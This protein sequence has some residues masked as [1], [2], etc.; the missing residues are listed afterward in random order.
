MRNPLVKVS[1]AVLMSAAV[2]LHADLAAQATS[3]GGSEIN[4]TNFKYAT[5]L[6]ESWRQA[7]RAATGLSNLNLFTFDQAASSYSV[8]SGGVTSTMT[9]TPGA[10]GFAW[11]TGGKLNTGS[12]RKFDFNFNGSTI[13][14]FSFRMYD[15]DAGTVLRIYD[16]TSSNSGELLWSWGSNST[17]TAGTQ[18][19]V[20]GAVPVSAGST[21]VTLPSAS[22]PLSGALFVGMKVAGSATYVTAGTTIT[23]INGGIIGLSNP[24]KASTSSL[25]LTFSPPGGTFGKFSKQVTYPRADLLGSA[26]KVGSWVTGTG[27][28]PLSFITA[29]NGN[30]LS[31]NNPTTA[32]GAGV[33]LTITRG[34]YAGSLNLTTT[35]G[36]AVAT[37]NGGLEALLG[38][39]GVANIYSTSRVSNNTA[40]PSI[41]VDRTSRFIQIPAAS[42]PLVAD[43]FVGMNV[44]GGLP[45]GTK[46]VSIVDAD[47]VELSNAPTSTAAT[48]TMTFAADAVNDAVVN[49]IDTANSRIT[50]SKAATYSA[51]FDAIAW[52]NAYLDSREGFYG[53][54]GLESGV[55]KIRLE[56]LGTGSSN[57][58]NVA[59]Y[60]STDTILHWNAANPQGLA[61]SGGDGSW[62]F[63]TTNW[64]SKPSSGSP[65]AF[66]DGKAV[67]FGGNQAGTVSLGGLGFS[68]GSMIFTQVTDP[69]A[70]PSRL[71]YVIGASAN[72]GTINLTEGSSIQTQRQATIRARIS[73]AYEKTGAAELIIEGTNNSGGL[74]KISQGRLQIMGTFGEQNSDILNSSQ[75]LINKTN[76]WTYANLLSGIGT[77]NKEGAGVLV[78]S[79]NNT[80]SGLTTIVAGPIV[81]GLPTGGLDIGAG[82]TEGALPGDINNGA[83]LRF[84]RSNDLT[85][86]KVISGSGAVTKL[87]AGTLTFLGANTYEGLTTISAG[88]LQIGNGASTGLG[89]AAAVVSDIKLDGATTELIYNNAGTKV[90]PGIISGTGKLTKRGS[91]TLQ[92][93][94]NNSYD[95]VTTI[96]SGRIDLASGSGLGSAVGHTIVQAGASLLLRDGF[97][98]AENITLIGTGDAS[99]GALRNISDT[100][101]LT[102]T[103]TLSGDTTLASGGGILDIHN[104]SGAGAKL[105][106]LST[107]ASNSAATAPLQLTNTVNLGSGRLEKTGEGSATLS[108][109]ANFTGGL[110]VLN[111]TL[112]AQSLTSFGQGTLVE[113][114]ATGVVNSPKLVI[115]NN[116]SF[117][118][119]VR[120]HEGEIAGPGTLTANTYDLRKGTVS[121]SLLGAVGLTKSSPDEV[122]LSGTNGYQGLTSVTGGVLAISNSQALGDLAAGTDV[123]AGGSL[124]LRK[125][126]GSYGLTINE[127]ITI[128]GAGNLGA[129]RNDIGVNTITSQLKLSGDA[130]I[131]ADGGGSKR[132]LQLAAVG[133]GS[134]HALTV[135]AESGAYVFFA[136]GYDLGGGRLVKK[137]AGILELSSAG[138]IDGSAQGD[139]VAIEIL[140]GRVVA[141]HAQAL[142]NGVVKVGSATLAGTL[143]IAVS[144]NLPGVLRLD[145]GLVSGVDLIAQS[146]D[147]RSGA[148]SA[149]L[150]TPSFPNPIALSKTSTGTVLLSG[151]NTYEGITEITGGV[152]QVGS[153]GL[154]SSADPL[155]D[156]TVVGRSGALE[157]TVGTTIANERIYIS[158]D[159]QGGFGALR[160]KGDGRSVAVTPTVIIDDLLDGVVTHGRINNR[161]WGDT[162]TLGGIQGANKDLYLGQWNSLAESDGRIHVNGPLSL[163]SGALIVEGREQSYYYVSDV[164]TVRL[165]GVGSF[166]GGTD[167]RSGVVIAAHP[168]AMGSGAITV[169]SATRRGVFRTAAALVGLGNITLVNGA[170]EGETIRGP[171]NVRFKYDIESPYV[172]LQKGRVSIGLAGA[173]SVAKTTAS[174]IGLNLANS[175]AGTTDVYAGILEMRNALSLG[176]AAAGTTVHPGATLKIARGRTVVANESLVLSGEGL[177]NIG[178]LHSAGGNNQWNGDISLDADARINASSTFTIGGASNLLGN[179]HDLKFGGSGAITLQK[180]LQLGLGSLIKDGYGSLT[181]A[182]AANVASTDLIRGR[183][184]LVGADLT[185]PTLTVR[186]GSVLAGYGR[187]FGDVTVVSGTN[188][189]LEPGT[190]TASAPAS[191]LS[192][193]TNS[194]TFADRATVRIQGLG[195]YRV[196]GSLDGPAPLVVNGDLTFGGAARRVKIAVSGGDPGPGKFRLF[197]YTGN[198][199]GDLSLGTLNPSILMSGVKKGFR[200]MFAFDQEVDGT[201]GRKFVTFTVQGSQLLWRG[202]RTNRWDIVTDNW[203]L[204]E[205]IT[206][207]VNV[208]QDDSTLFDD[209]ADGNTLIRVVPG[210]NGIKPVSS[211]TFANTDHR[212][213]LNPGKEYTLYRDTTLPDDNGTAVDLLQTESVTIG[214]PDV[215]PGKQ[216]GV[217]NIKTALKILPTPDLEVGET[218]YNG[219]ILNGGTLRIGH[220]QALGGA[221]VDLRGGRLTAFES[222]ARSVAGAHEVHLDSD[223]VVFGEAGHEG[224]LTFSSTFDFTDVAPRIFNVDA[225]AE[226]RLAGTVIGA[227]ITKRGTGTLTLSSADIFEGSVRV[228]NGILQLGAGGLNGSLDVDTDIDLAGGEFRFNRGGNPRGDSNSLAFA[229][230]IVGAGTL[231]KI[232]VGRVDLSGNHQIG[233]GAYI[234]QGNLAINGELTGSVTVTSGGILSGAGIVNGNV[235]VGNGARHEP[236]NSPGLATYNGNLTYT[237]GATIV[238]QLN[239]NTM[240][241][242]QAG[243]AYDRIVVNG[244]LAFGATPNT[245]QMAFKDT[246]VAGVPGEVDWTNDFWKTAQ[247]WKIFEVSGTT[248]GLSTGLLLGGVAGTYEDASSTQLSNVMAEAYFKITQVGQDVFLNY[249]PYSAQVTSPVDLGVAYVGS[250]F[251]QGNV[252]IRNSG[253]NPVDVELRDLVVRGVAPNKGPFGVIVPPGSNSVLGVQGGTADSSMLVEMN[254]THVGVVS[255]TIA[256]DFRENNGP[257]ST[258]EILTVRGTAYEQAAPRTDVVDFGAVRISDPNKG[259]H[260]AAGIAHLRTNFTQQRVQLYNDAHATYGEAMNASLSAPGAGLTVSSQVVQQVLPGTVN[261]DLWADLATPSVAGQ[262]NPQATLSGVSLKAHPDLPGANEKPLTAQQVQFT[263]KAYYHAFGVVTNAPGNLTY[264]FGSVRKGAAFSVSS[265]EVLNDVTPGAY[266]ENLGATLLANDGKIIT[267]GAITGLA[268]GEVNVA[269]PLTITLSSTRAGQIAGTATLILKTEPLAGSGLSSQEITRVEFAVT[270]EVI[271]PAQIDDSLFNLGRVHENGSFAVQQLPIKNLTEAPGYTDNLDVD[272][273]TWDPGLEVNGPMAIRGL[274][275][276]QVDSSISVKIADQY[277]GSRGVYTKY[278][279]LEGTSKSTDGTLTTP[280]GQTAIA[281]EGVVYNGKSTWLGGSDAWTNESWNRW[282]RTEGVPG[283]DG[284]LSTYDSATFA[285][286]ENQNRTVIL[287]GYNPELARLAFGGTSGT[288]LRSAVAEEI[289]LGG[290]GLPTAAEVYIGASAHRIDTKLNLKQ[291]LLIKVDGLRG[292]FAGTIQATDAQSKDIWLQG[293]G[294]V[295]FISAVTGNGWDMNVT[296]QGPTLITQSQDFDQFKLEAGAVIS[297]HY[298]DGDPT[299]RVVNAA[300]CLKLTGDTVS[301]GTATQADRSAAELLKI[302]SLAPVDVQAG[303]LYNNAVIDA[304]VVVR[305]G[306]KLGGVGY[307]GPIQ[308]AQGGT[309]A[310]GN[311]IGD[312]TTTSLNVAPGA[313]YQVEFNGTGADKVIVTPP[314][315]ATV[316]GGIEVVFYPGSIDVASQVFTIIDHASLIHDIAPDISLDPDIE[317]N[318]VYFDAATA[319]LF[320]SLTPY[321]RTVDDNTRTELYF[322]LYRNLGLP[323]TISSAPSILGRTNS[324]FVRSIFGDPC[325]RLAARGPST[326]QG[327][328]LNSLLGS[329]NDIATMVSGALDNSW[330]QG[331][332]ETISA[333]QGSGDWGYDFQLGGVSAG[334]DLVRRPN[335]V[336]GLAFGLSESS[337]THDYKGDRTSGRAYDFGV[338]AHAKHGEADVN[339]VAFVSKYALTH[340][341]FVDMG[342]TTKPAVGKPDAYRAGIAFGYDAKVHAT[343]ESDAFLRMGVGGGLMSRGAFTE[344]GDEAIAMDFDA[345]RVPY[346]QFDL[347]LTY[348]HDL[349]RSDKSWRVFGEAMLTRHVSVSPDPGMARFVTAVG[350]ST[351]VAV[352]SPEYTYLQVRPAVGVSW[353]KGS[354]SA[355]LKV[356]TELR[357]GKSSPGASLNYRHQF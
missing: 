191:M 132:S 208:I 315:G 148:V 167:I 323:R 245:L 14:G 80:F 122:L 355:E 293:G 165:S 115:D 141:R 241:E 329:R 295:G 72:E 87:G 138:S 271:G 341:R 55:G 102:G 62:N 123:A 330:V 283:R 291:D 207:R 79:R 84:N 257:V 110:Y 139:G 100:N 128:A 195:N 114:G 239:D 89:S 294:E 287:T 113:V 92:L 259:Y 181:L 49:S 223:A 216:W 322:G 77:L 230:D 88:K 252:T 71:S 166:T 193:A 58:D 280:L 6:E 349:F 96:E 108:G 273:V 194:L 298:L 314:G 61:P 64:L 240:S 220:D 174:T 238:W 311:S 51:T 278:L 255:G 109:V 185:S 63:T 326:A 160:T 69:G 256:V 86:D 310:P 197:E 179:G 127:E 78:L 313:T 150:G 312:I 212:D 307:T 320:P 9:V 284:A 81:N 144:T 40:I 54:S 352:A 247:R 111:G 353:N 346:F 339:F 303:T 175:Y 198:L 117:G 93:T 130:T 158:G 146:Y 173:G 270:G 242:G 157:L 214:K 169:G 65:V 325:S 343:A 168:D 345:A 145:K 135:E 75:L 155:T 68:L 34:Y 217:V 302:A 36:S 262:V 184:S 227:G 338:Y 176:T 236:G 279:T 286:N 292:L 297:R 305:N 350:N 33:A 106:L 290:Q 105:T 226:L 23:S 95:G 266:S 19:V 347:G 296:L 210:T 268:P 335:S 126:S 203:S 204:T 18:A 116:T 8:T 301:L 235:I 233:G 189:I 50:L 59:F 277:T 327:L 218:D 192:L 332:G 5:K 24:L 101:H 199:T 91:G 246:G 85:H 37:V 282:A 258:T 30:T 331:Y 35:A 4:S 56:M 319:A 180:S 244:D 250:S 336:V 7:A 342:I 131:Y 26:V 20:V 188:S 317:K 74:V 142:G 272:V 274:A 32:A 46:I 334:L 316:K 321:I 306:A 94:A 45:A 299:Q 163:G 118:G 243:S 275:G 31:L 82:G 234:D 98:S 267:T 48:V 263:G 200:Q 229:G 232:G 151:V 164:S 67:S 308:V 201:S 211:M 104:V 213:A 52:E 83:L 196:D 152:L 90:L 281:V 276:D 134:A 219:L 137:G 22:L 249:I 265:L 125:P 324:L 21:F 1:K 13:N 153:L 260:T 27:I 209:R 354:N 25:S 251:G 129:L 12:D 253:F 10:A 29:I 120:L 11:L 16:T 154:G 304:A 186:P 328:T 300:N 133:D 288:V 170:L 248:T 333:N 171:G 119:V 264:S 39:T 136:G 38:L 97:Y 99:V 159:G 206:P 228:E 124:V 147:L 112:Y 162:L 285:G 17:T 225:A 161:D 205:N 289:V 356:F 177:G 178:A 43:L 182:A 344:T 183:L 269:Q 76:N 337:A 222:D 309:L 156:Y 224:R 172:E 2:L 202:T 3:Y 149:S 231:R 103:L 357:A 57:L 44:T 190:K 340:T 70:P 237:G 221:R 215:L 121:A 140:G 53:F 107:V 351:E 187:V 261:S 47:T 60:S 41:P 254:A 66:I 318:G 15:P 348:G 28:A 73:S 42:L 143:D